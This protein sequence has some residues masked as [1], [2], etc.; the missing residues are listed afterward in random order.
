MPTC[1]P[2]PASPRHASAQRAI[3]FII[4]KWRSC[5]AIWGGS[6]SASALSS[7]SIAV[8]Y[9]VSVM[10]P[11]VE[12]SG[13]KIASRPRARA[14]CKKMSEISR[15]ARRVGKSSNISSK[16][17][18]A[19]SRLRV[20]IINQR[21]G[22]RVQKM[23]SGRDGKQARA[24]RIGHSPLYHSRRRRVQFERPDARTSCAACT[25]SG[26]PTCIH[27]PSSTSP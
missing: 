16:S 9:P 8:S 23:L 5:G 11:S 18:S 2:Y 24:G 10:S 6:S 20:R 13:S 14:N 15:T 17:R 25:P 26:V 12:I 3:M 7:P 1:A 21:C 22:Q 27:R 4:W 19:K